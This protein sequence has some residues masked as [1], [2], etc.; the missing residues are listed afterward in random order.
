MS[1]LTEK[2]SAVNPSYWISSVVRVATPAPTLTTTPEAKYAVF[3]GFFGCFGI[4]LVIDI[5]T[6]GMVGKYYLPNGQVSFADLPT[7]FARYLLAFLLVWA[8]WSG[9]MRVT[10]HIYIKSPHHVTICVSRTRI[11]TCP[12][13]AKNQPNLPTHISATPPTVFRSEPDFGTCPWAGNFLP[14]GGKTRRYQCPTPTTR[15]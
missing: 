10:V 8:G 1:N 11:Y 4:C 2:F 12:L 7:D 5:A 6:T 15:S 13:T 3:T 9:C 14:I